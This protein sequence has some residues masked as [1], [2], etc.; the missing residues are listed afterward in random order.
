MNQTMQFH[1]TADRYSLGSASSLATLYSSPSNVT[2]NPAVTLRNVGSNGGQAAA[3]TYDLARSIVYTRQGNPSWAGQERDGIAPMRPD[4]L[5]FGA[6]TNDMQT[7]WVNLDKVAIPQADEQQRLLANLILAME[8]TKALLPR[9][10]YFPHGYPAVVVMTGDDHSVGGTNAVRRFN[11]YLAASAP[12]GSLADWQLPRCTMYTFLP[13][14]GLNDSQAATYQSAGFEIGIHLYTGCADYTPGDLAAMFAQQFS[15]LRSYYPS[16]ALPVTDRIHCIAWSGYSEPAEVSSQWGVR[17]DTSYYYWPT[18]WVNNRPGFMTGSGMPMRFATTNGSAID[19]FQAATQMTDESGQ[20]YP[21]T[22][23]TLLDRALGADG[24]FGAFVANMHTD[25]NVE[26]EA[27]AILASALARGV[28]VI[29]ANQLLTWVDARNNSS[30]KSVN[31]DGSRQNF[32]IVADTA[33]HGLM[34]MSPIPAGYT[35]AGV[36]RN[37]SPVELSLV[38]VK[39]VRYALFYSSNG[40]YQVSYA[41]DSIPPSITSVS[42]ANGATGVDPATSIRVDFSE[43]LD[44]ATVNNSTVV[45]YDSLSNPVAGTVTYDPST[46]E[47]ILQPSVSLLGSQTYTVGVQGGESGIRD[48]AGNPLPSNYAWTFTTAAVTAYSFWSG[49]AIPSLV[50][51]GADNPVQLGIKF[52]SD[53]AGY[54]TGIRFYKASANIGTHVAGLWTSTG[55][56]LGAAT[57]V[58]ESASGWQQVNFATPIAIAANTEYVA[59]YHATVGHYSADT[60]YFEVAGWDAGPLHVPSSGSSGGNGV[61]AYGDSTTFPNFTW[62]AANYWVDIV[63]QPAIP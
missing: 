39:G 59:S 45:L 25:A 30:I 35:V 28:P 4:D 56:R 47:A 41:L 27:D 48:F 57:F 19:I 34:A 3:F 23:D 14:P 32:S 17:L 21:Y 52:R 40:N 44:A 10:W 62:Q 15:D 53:V 29:A 37:G 38:T 49:S 33:A 7:D 26:P 16:V 13:N 31:W 50:D 60:D 22:I 63:F 5:F 54:V 24:F 11:Q 1:G 6:K 61:Y 46:H 9:F 55:T 58:G 20:S 8:S 51:G 2:P 36:I 18:T 12:G 43:S 42:P